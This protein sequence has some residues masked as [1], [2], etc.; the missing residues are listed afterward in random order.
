VVLVIDPNTANEETIIN[1]NWS[2][3]SGTTITATFVNNHTAPYV[4]WQAGTTFLNTQALAWRVANLNALVAEEAAGTNELLFENP[5]NT[6][7]LITWANDVPRF[8]GGGSSGG[9]IFYG[10]QGGTGT[11]GQIRFRNNAADNTAQFIFDTSQGNLSLNGLLRNTAATA[12]MGMTLRK[13]SGA[14]NYTTASTTYIVADAT[15]LCGTFTIPVGWKLG[16]Q[17]SGSIGTST[18]IAAA[19]A[20]L[21]DNA[22]CSTAN[23]GLLAEAQVDAG[24]VGATAGFSLSWVITGDGNAHNVALQIKTAAGAD[25]ALL[26]NSS[27]TALP[28][29]AFTLMPSN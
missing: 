21:T 5:T 11:S 22:A 7:L 9:F 19:S 15:N 20:A 6:P 25:S 29:M 18:A 12:T 8:Y 14:G 4:V 10:S 28:T 23:A 1:A 13:G 3:A 27:S 2:I 24:A 16:I 17:A 26:L